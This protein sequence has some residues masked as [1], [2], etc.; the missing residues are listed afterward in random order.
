M[1]VRVIQQ[2]GTSEESSPVT[3]LMQFLQ[4][5]SLFF[6]LINILSKKLIGFFYLV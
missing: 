6:K 5:W 4:Q 2:N 1:L 3:H